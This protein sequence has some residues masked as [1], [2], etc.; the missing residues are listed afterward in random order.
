MAD[1]TSARGTFTKSGTGAFQHH[2][3]ADCA[4]VYSPSR[5]PPVSMTALQN[6]AELGKTTIESFVD[7]ALP[8][9]PQS[10]EKIEPGT[11]AVMQARDLGITLERETF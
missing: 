9:L 5:V 10:V 6:F 3:N 2:L 8:S 7:V 1:P 4:Q 11:G